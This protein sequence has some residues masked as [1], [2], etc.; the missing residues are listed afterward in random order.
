MLIVGA[1]FIVH[2]AL[3]VHGIL[4]RPLSRALLTL[5]RQWLAYYP[6]TTYLAPEHGLRCRR[7]E[8]GLEY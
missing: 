1:V 6:R 2:R 4:F 8:A 3:R 7:R 5:Q